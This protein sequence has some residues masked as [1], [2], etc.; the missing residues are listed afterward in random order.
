[1]TTVPPPLPDLDVLAADSEWV[2][3]QDGLAAELTVLNRYAATA[4]PRIRRQADSLSQARFTPS[5]LAIVAVTFLRFCWFTLLGVVG[6]AGAF[7]RRRVLRRGAQPARTG[8][9]S[10]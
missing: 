2:R 1:M 3:G 8:R 5:T 7:G 4:L 10:A 6:E 9:P